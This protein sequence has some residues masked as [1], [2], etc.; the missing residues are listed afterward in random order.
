MSVDVSCICLTH[1]RPWL[2]AE[3]VESFRRQRLGDL[4][5]ELLIV[6]DCVEQTLVCDVPGVVVVNVSEHIFD[7]SAKTNLAL[8]MCN[9]RCACLWD[10]DDISLPD[11][12]SD[13]VARM[14]GTL[15][16]RPTL[17]WSWGCG[18]IRHMGQPL[19]CSAM[20][21]R[22]HAIASG[23]CVPGEWNDKSLW[24][25]FWPTGNVVQ[26]APTPV[27]AQYIYRWA[28]IGWHESGGGEDDSAVRA[29]FTMYWSL[30]MIP[31]EAFKHFINFSL[32]GV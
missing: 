26:Y 6:N 4:T 22:A 8:S 11:R 31:L 14:A 1:G 32:G 9:G 20:F 27:E 17:C 10:D 3:A 7:L 30:F 16:Y 13:G 28:G 29:A 5:A 19:L 23:G 2:L 12:I 15:A 25:R 24:G 21:D 18:E